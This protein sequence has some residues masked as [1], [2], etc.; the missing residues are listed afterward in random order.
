M[1]VSSGCIYRSC[2]SSASIGTHIFRIAWNSDCNICNV[3]SDVCFLSEAG[4]KDGNRSSFDAAGIY[5]E[6]SAS[7]SGCGGSGWNSG[8]CSADGDG[9]HCLL[10][11]SPCKGS[12][13]R[14]PG[15]RS[16]ELYYRYDGFCKE[17]AYRKRD[18]AV[19]SCRYY[20]YFSSLWN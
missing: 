5:A 12:G 13:G 14:N 8:I 18:V 10:S 20:L 11:D 1:C 16:R 6:G 19:C 3:S 7:D 15:S 17:V 4:S 2:G 9:N